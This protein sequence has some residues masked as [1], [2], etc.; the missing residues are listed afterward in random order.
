MSVLNIEAP[1]APPGQLFKIQVFYDVDAAVDQQQAVHRL[2]LHR[3]HFKRG[4]VG[5]DHSGALVEQPLR[6][7]HSRTRYA[8]TPAVEQL[9]IA[10]ELRPSGAYQHHVARL[11]L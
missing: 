7:F 8:A 11:N 10:P 2:A 3:N 4:G 1:G 5:A 9:R 6:A